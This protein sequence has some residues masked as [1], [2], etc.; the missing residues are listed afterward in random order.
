MVDSQQHLFIQGNDDDDIVPSLPLDE[1]L[2]ASER[3]LWITDAMP[4]DSTKLDCFDPTDV[5]DSVSQSLDHLTYLSPSTANVL[6][7]N[8]RDQESEIPPLSLGPSTTLHSL[9]LDPPTESFSPCDETIPPDSSKLFAEF[10]D[11]LEQSTSGSDGHVCDGFPQQPDYDIRRVSCGD[12][13]T[14]STDVSER[15]KDGAR[16]S[17]FKCEPSSTP[18]DPT[19]HPNTDSPNGAG[20]S[21]S[22]LSEGSSMNCDTVCKG[23]AK[24]PT[25][26]NITIQDLKRVFHYERPRAEKE[27]GL[28][29]TTFSNLS[30]HFGI[31]K[32]PYRTL[33]DVHKRF[34]ANE[35][36]LK[37]VEISKEKRRKLIDQ[38]DNLQA[39][40]KLIYDDPSKSR[41]TNTLAVL[42]RIVANRKRGHLGSDLC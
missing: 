37:G 6:A 20:I 33:R 13:S 14:L 19:E 4:S 26:A 7:A 12:I 17:P 40:T 1:L 42:L 25:T 27:L 30:R 2:S 18:P 32:W 39:V 29:R 5:S 24:P 38:Q 41:D 22:E 36:L 3:M 21:C 28:K 10:N 23:V 34:T 35:V 11:R 9:C 15:L 16:I 8:S 31:S